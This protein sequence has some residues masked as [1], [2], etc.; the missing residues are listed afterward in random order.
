M[1]IEES[2]WVTNGRN[3]IRKE[4]L[5][6]RVINNDLNAQLNKCLTDQETEQVTN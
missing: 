5:P 3:K 4:I 1:E 6:L 2:D